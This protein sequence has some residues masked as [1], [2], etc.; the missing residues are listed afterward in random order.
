MRFPNFILFTALC[1][2]GAAIGAEQAPYNSST[3]SGLGARNIGSA[4]MSGRISAFAA[5]PGAVRAN[6]RFTSARP[7]AAFGN[8]RTA[9]RA[10]S[11]SSTSNR[12]NRSA[13]SRSIPR[14][15][16]TSG[17]ARAN[18]GRATASR[19]ATESTSRPM[20]ARPGPIPGCRIRS[21]S[22]RSSSVP[23]AAT[24]FSRP[25][26]ARSGAIRRIAASTRR[27]MA[28]R[29]GTSRS[30]R[31]QPFHRLFRH[32]ARS[33]RPEQHVR[34]PCGISGAKAGPSAPA[35]TVPTSL[36]AAACFASTDG[37]A[38]WTEITPENSKGFPK[39]PYGRIAVA[40]APSNA[41]R[42]LRFCRI[43]R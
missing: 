32:R 13:R 7:A 6:S 43:D 14:I 30:Q 19:S 10:T 1:L 26:R 11:R 39:K 3:I 35:A 38:T 17:S 16:R 28:A 42:R 23:R 15:R 20:A 9:A 33:R 4:A 34:R 31:R 5:T 18:R 29:P 12:C 36:P 24:R 25:C 22:P 41:E 27:P 21:A 37:G 8:P 40:I 2:A